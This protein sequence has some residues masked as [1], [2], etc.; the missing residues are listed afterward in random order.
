VA[1]VL[2]GARS[3]DDLDARSQAAVRAE[4]DA[5]IEARRE[6]LNLAE[7]FAAEGRSWVEAG[8]DGTTVR[9]SAPAGETRQRR[10]AL[11]DAATKSASGSRTHAGRSRKDQPTR[12]ATSRTD[13]AATAS[14]KKTQVTKKAAAQKKTSA[15][16]G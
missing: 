11:S 5:R 4:W 6:A 16:G 12:A 8:P 3:Y 7:R 2:A 15:R 14:T 1:E 10:G 9:R 13:R